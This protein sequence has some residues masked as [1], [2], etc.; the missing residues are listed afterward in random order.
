MNEHKGNVCFSYIFR[1]AVFEGRGTASI[2]DQIP[3]TSRSQVKNHTLA[4]CSPLPTS[5]FHVYGWDEQ[6]YMQVRRGARKNSEGAKLMPWNL[7]HRNSFLFKCTLNE[8]KG[9][10]HACLR[11]RLS[12]CQ[13]HRVQNLWTLAINSGIESKHSAVPTNFPSRYFIILEVLLN[14]CPLESILVSI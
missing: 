7:L 9:V 11:W 1:Y 2:S 6:L 12:F 8:L 5:P 14:N 3:P 13:N 4:S 10:S